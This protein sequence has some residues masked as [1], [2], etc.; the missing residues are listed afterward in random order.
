METTGII[1]KWVNVLMVVEKGHMGRLR[2]CLDPKD[3]N[4]AIK[5]PHYPL[6]TL[7]DITARLAG[8]HYFSVLD[9]CS[10]YW[11][12]KLLEESSKL[13]T[14]NKPFGHYRLN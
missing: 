12:I 1:A 5:C 2:V 6:P 4:K 14:F 7:E 8:A 11:A 9:A 3:L 10:G 13:M